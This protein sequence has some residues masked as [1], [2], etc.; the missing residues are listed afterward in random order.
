LKSVIS[1]ISGKNGNKDGSPQGKEMSNVEKAFDLYMQL[2]DSKYVNIT[3]DA[4]LNVAE[5]LENR[6]SAELACE[7]I[8]NVINIPQ[9][10]SDSVQR[11]TAL[12]RRAR[13]K[14]KQGK[15]RESLDDYLLL[16]DLKMQQ[17]STSTTS[18]NYLEKISH[19]QRRIQEDHDTNQ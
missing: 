6:G 7:F 12:E 4:N 8:T 13:L 5:V 16:R 19:L 18:I 9:L 14:E 1:S 2:L 3:A 11:I 17:D 15:W 10:R